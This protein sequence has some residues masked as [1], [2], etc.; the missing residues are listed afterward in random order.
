MHCEAPD[1]VQGLDNT[2]QQGAVEAE[3]ED[4]A[5]EDDAPGL[6]GTGYDQ[7]CENAFIC[8]VTLDQVDQLNRLVERIKA[9][10][11][12]VSAN[13]AADFAPGTLSIL[14][15]TIFDRAVELDALVSEIYTQTLEQ[16]PRQPFSVRETPPAYCAQLGSG[17][18]PET[19][20]PAMSRSQAWT[21]HLR[22]DAVLLH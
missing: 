18:E 7:P 19:D 11:D 17:L 2:V 21:A 6:A 22:Q 3:A 12:A 16:D 15:H 9:Y 5:L 13:G 8:G 14:G 10:G 4:E 1:E 20:S